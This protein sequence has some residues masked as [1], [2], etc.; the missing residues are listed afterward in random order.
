[1]DQEPPMTHATAANV[2]TELLN[3]D[4]TT[5]RDLP[6]KIRL[7]QDPTEESFAVVAL[8]HASSVLSFLRRS[9]PSKEPSK[10]AKNDD[11]SF[12]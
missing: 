8:N 10:P 4:P 2:S 5:T 1:M 11:H 7:F 9:R 3:S 12:I 6:K